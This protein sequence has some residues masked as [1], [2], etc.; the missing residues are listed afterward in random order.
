MSDVSVVV[1]F[2]AESL[3]AH[4]ALL[5]LERVRK[6]SEAS[7]MTVEWVCVLDAASVETSRVV[8]NSP[9][10]RSCDQILKVS[11]KDL[12]ASRNS[13][14]AQA[15]G[16]FVAICDGDDYYSKDWL[17]AAR[18]RLLG[19]PEPLIVHPELCVS[20]GAINCLATVVDMERCD[21]P[22]SSCLTVHPWVSTS[23]APRELYLKCPYQ[24]TDL[25]ITGFGFE[26]WH[27]N[28]ETLAQG[29]KHVTAP[30]TALF[31][32]RKS[33]SMVTAMASSQAVVRP[34]LFFD[35][36]GLIEGGA[37]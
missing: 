20:F 4:Y 6:A 22:L 37:K 7:G 27:W 18:A 17:V 16:R 1:T 12:G 21:Y 26:D 13:G 33:H 3:I 5:G 2:H 28:L 35:S 34:T 14:I 29:W 9:V 24:R 11:N 15:R 23:F 30:G 31:Y 36:P 8:E 32:R 25:A 10:L 19:S